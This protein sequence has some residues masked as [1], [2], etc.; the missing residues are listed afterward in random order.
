M[1]DVFHSRDFVKD[2]RR[3]GRKH[4]S[5]V[6]ELFDLIADEIMVS[7]MVDA[8]YQP[9]VLNNRGGIYNGCMEFHLADNVLVIFSPPFPDE[10]VT[11]RRICTHAELSSGIFNIE[12]PDDSAEL[13][14][15]AG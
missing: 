5:L 14:E 7:G 6:R 15:L 11:M 1:I 8:A 10:S 12:W 3:L 2:A 9:H 13:P 4:P